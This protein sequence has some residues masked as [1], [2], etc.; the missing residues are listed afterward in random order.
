MSQYSNYLRP[1]FTDD[2]IK[3]LQKGYSINLIAIDG[4]G[5]RRLLEDI[6]N[7]NLKNTK[8]FYIDMN[9]YRENYQEFMSSLWQ[10]LDEKE[11]EPL[12]DLESL[13]NLLEEK[14]YRVIIILH[15]FDELLDNSLVDKQFARNFF[16]QLNHLCQ[17]QKISLLCVTTQPHDQSLVFINEKPVC[18]CWL[19]LEKKRLPKLTHDEIKFELK[20]RKLPLST[21]E[22]SQVT[23]AVHGHEKPYRLLNFFV[24]KI[25]HQE[26]SELALSAR[27][28]LW[29]QQFKKNNYRRFKRR[30]DKNHQT[31]SW[32]TLVT[33]KIQAFLF[34]TLEFCKSWLVYLIHNNHKK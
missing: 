13:I 4:Q 17:R 29:T 31:T 22:L 14:E 5:R 21:N 27:L 34:S 20:C 33:L 28:K 12:N 26:D 23:W 19:E 24:D 1:I 6:K 30:I 7:S 2:L 32:E 10:Q 15:H 18:Y 9:E 25:V 3:T 11:K 16:T 8:I